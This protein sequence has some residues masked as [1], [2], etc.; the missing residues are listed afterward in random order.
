MGQ[1]LPGG[2]LVC[3]P[4]PDEFF[5]DEVLSKVGRV[6]KERPSIAA[7]AYGFNETGA[8][9]KSISEATDF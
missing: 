5:A 2:I 4:G 7:F 3:R 6:L 8:N 1:P 9:A